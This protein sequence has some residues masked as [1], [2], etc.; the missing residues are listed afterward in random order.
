MTD[1]QIEKWE[2]KIKDSLLRRDSTLGNASSSMK[3]IMSRSFEINGKTYSLNTF[4]I[5]TLGYFSADTNER[6]CLHI[7]GDA[8]DSNTSG[9]ADKLMAAINEDPE[10]VT[11]FFQQLS[12][13]LYDDLTKRMASS[14]VSSIY[15]I[16]NDKQMSSEYSDYKDKISKW[17]DKLDYYEEYYYKKFSAME[18]A[19]SKLQSSTSSL[20]NLLGS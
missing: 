1:S 19:L 12:N 9:N 16:Y 14:S 3:S 18:T 17:E 11:S 13:T 15:T 4:G 8:D 2:T 20:S 10:A 7:D 6:G 5:N